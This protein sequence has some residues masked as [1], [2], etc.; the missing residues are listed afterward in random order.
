MELP[1]LDGISTAVIE[2]MV[3]QSNFSSNYTTNLTLY[4]N[5]TTCG[6]GSVT[7]TIPPQR[8]KGK[9]ES[10]FGA[11]T[12]HIRLAYKL[13]IIKS[14]NAFCP[15]C[16]VR[17]FT[18]KSISKISFKTWCIQLTIKQYIFYVF[19]NMS[20]EIERLKIYIIPEYYWNRLPKHC[21]TD[22]NL[23]PGAIFMLV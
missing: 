13:L 5:T 16:L 12:F 3:I 17:S 9:N 20:F 8:P 6:N 10:K 4:Y 15:S 19:I 1:T 14:T 18:L 2:C 7:R 21:S 11:V 22:E 23:K